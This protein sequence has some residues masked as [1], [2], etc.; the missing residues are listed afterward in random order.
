MLGGEKGGGERISVRDIVRALGGQYGQ[1]YILSQLI[2]L[3]MIKGSKIRTLE[4]S[5]SSEILKIRVPGNSNVQ[6]IR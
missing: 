4:S 5:K 6:L 3:Q 1:I 2:K